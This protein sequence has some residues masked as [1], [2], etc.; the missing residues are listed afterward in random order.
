MFKNVIS[1]AF[2]E[3]LLCMFFLTSCTSSKQNYDTFSMQNSNKVLVLYAS[4]DPLWL[5]YFSN[6]FTRRIQNERLYQVFENHEINKE[7]LLNS[8]GNL[9]DMHIEAKLTQYG[10][11]LQ[12]I[13]LSGKHAKAYKLSNQYMQDAYYLL[14]NQPASV[15]YS[16][17]ILAFWASVSNLKYAKANAIKYA[18][19]YEKY[20]PLNLKDQLES[21]V[22][23][24][25]ID[26][27]KEM[28]KAY[29]INQKTVIISNAR[30]CNVYVN[31]QELKVNKVLL[32][33]KM[34]SI[35]SASCAHGFFSQTITAEK[36]SEVKIIPYYPASFHSMPPLTSLPKDLLAQFKLAAILLIYW[37]HS[38]KYLEV[39]IINP[40]QILVVTK[41]RI[42]LSSKKNVDEAGDLL[43]SFLKINSPSLTKK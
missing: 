5:P 22:D 30:N 20:L 35:V 18:I 11:K 13:F 38:G 33:P 19:I 14:A 25:W 17:A 43:I 10:D 4:D 21:Q 39:Q 1:F 3:V 23:T 24:H 12:E 42:D 8:I 7:W 37:S 29:I 6:A 15:A 2:F 31:G 27:L 26:Q 40:K 9:K 32:P 36:I 41:T 16:Y 28:T 34:H